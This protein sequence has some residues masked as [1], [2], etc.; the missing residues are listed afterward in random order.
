M[1]DMIT[2]L[3]SVEE[4]V[5]HFYEFAGKPIRYG[6]LF[7]TYYYLLEVKNIKSLRKDFEDIRNNLWIAFYNY[8]IFTSAFDLHHMTG[9]DEKLK[10]VLKKNDYNKKLF[11]VFNNQKHPTL[12]VKYEEVEKFCIFM[13]QEFKAFSNSTRFLKTCYDVFKTLNMQPQIKICNTMLRRNKI[14]PTIFVDACWNLV[15]ESYIH[16]SNWICDDEMYS[17]SDILNTTDKWILQDE[18]LELLNMLLEERLE[19]KI[20]NMYGLSLNFDPSLYRYETLIPDW[21][22]QN[23]TESS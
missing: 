12:G 9:E 22:K 20:Y 1:N 21:M 6:S 17:F 16:W 5:K 23:P 3:R 10:H 2:K 8:G 7:Y 13:E 19:G 18:Y 15:H 14:R 4:K 11:E